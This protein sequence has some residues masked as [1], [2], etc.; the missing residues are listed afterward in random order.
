MMP[1]VA[2]PI[3]AA[4][5]VVRSEATPWSCELKR[6]TPAP[7]PPAV[8]PS[9]PPPSAHMPQR[10]WP[11]PV[12]RSA[13]VRAHTIPFEQPFVVIIFLPLVVRRPGTA[14]CQAVQN[15]ALGPWLGKRSRDEIWCIRRARTRVDN[16]PW[17]I[18]KGRGLTDETPTPSAASG[19]QR[20]LDGQ[21][22]ALAQ[23][24][25]DL[26]NGAGPELRPGLRQYAI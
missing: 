19:L 1:P 21:V 11:Q 22:E 14:A 4:A 12:A 2:A 24:M 17:R 26:I 18:L 23:R 15:L 16:P 25:V 6:M 10:R 13:T 9:R 8:A 5:A 20:E 3:E 7:T